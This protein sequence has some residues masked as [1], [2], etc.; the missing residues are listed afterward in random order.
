MWAFPSFGCFLETIDEQ[1]PSFMPA[2]Q[3][4]ALLI[5]GWGGIAW[6][7]YYKY[8]IE[9]ELKRYSG[10]GLGGLAVVAPFALGFFGGITGEILF[11]SL[12]H[13]PLYDL[14]STA[15][16]GGFAWIYVMQF[17]LYSKVNELYQSRGLTP[18]L[19]VWGLLV[20]GY[21][22]VTG[23]RQIHFLS[24]FWAMERGEAPARDAFCELFPFATKQT[25]GVVELFINP[26]LWV[27]WDR[28]GMTPPKIGSQP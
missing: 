20:P 15:F 17:K 3:K 5:N 14:C 28:L 22:F 11:G 21:N 10:E 7:L 1:P 2:W 19:L 8:Q 18:P 9:E 27:R 26:E 6:Y 24:Q 16:W 23:I 12:E 4:W 25:L 13:E